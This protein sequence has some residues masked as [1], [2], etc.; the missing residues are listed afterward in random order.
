MPRTDYIEISSNKSSPIQNHLT[1][2]SQPLNNNTDLVT[3]LDTSL[4]LTFPPSTTVQ[5]TLSQEPLT[6]PLAP[7][8]LT[9]STPPTSPL[10][11][12]PYLSFLNGIPLR[13]SNPLPQV[14]S[15]GLS[16]TLPQPPPI[17]HEPSFPPINLS[18]SRLS[19]QPEPSMTRDEI[20]QELNQLH[21]LE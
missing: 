6:L 7:R 2:T 21:T 15:Q 5:T 1:N 18:R 13:S 14:I 19:A 10:G 12:H 17:D 20:H 8:A 4:A 9:F 16:Q 3:T 11:P